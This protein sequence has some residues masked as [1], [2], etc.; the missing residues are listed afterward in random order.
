MSLG[1]SNTPTSFSKNYEQFADYC[2]HESP[3]I[4]HYFDKNWKPC[5]DMWANYARSL[6]FSAG[7]TT[8]NRIEAN[9]NQLKRLTGSRPSIDRTVEGLLLH[10]VAVVRKFCYVVGRHA[11]T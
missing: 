1:G 4:M 8:T 9:W 5:S 3:V 2:R 11:T 10:Q 7:N 6:F